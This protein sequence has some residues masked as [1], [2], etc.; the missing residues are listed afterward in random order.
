MSYEWALPTL[1]TNDTNPTATYTCTLICV[2]T[3][4]IKCKHYTCILM[5]AM[6]LQSLAIRIHY[7][8][9]CACT[10][11]IKTSY[12]TLV[13]RYSCINPRPMLRDT[14]GTAT[15]LAHKISTRVEP[16]MQI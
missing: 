13:V 4:L 8:R 5:A 14:T 10:C 15:L 6:I 12:A 7:T 2:H 1:S 9:I 16:E 11:M 3:Q